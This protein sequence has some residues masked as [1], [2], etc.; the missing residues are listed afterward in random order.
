MTIVFLTLIWYLSKHYF[1][2][3]KLS[4]KNL[5]FFYFI[6]LAL[7]M[8]ELLDNN[9]RVVYLIKKIIFGLGAYPIQQAFCLIYLK[10]TKDP[11]DGVSKLDFINLVSIT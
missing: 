6:E 10:Q 8:L 4:L 2:E 1:I 3:L 9:N 7:T 11:L 5:V